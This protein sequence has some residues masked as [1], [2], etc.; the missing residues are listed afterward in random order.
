MGWLKRL[1]GG[2]P[3]D[4]EPLSVESKT[5][6]EA[7]K[8]EHRTTI[9]FFDA[10]DLESALDEAWN[11]AAPP[12]APSPQPD[13]E[14]ASVDEDADVA[15]S[16][17]F[18]VGPERDEERGA[19]CLDAS[20]PRYSREWC[21]GLTDAFKKQLRRIDRK[22]QKRVEEAIAAIVRSPLQPRGKTVQPLTGQ[23]K[24]LWRYR[25]GDYRLIYEPN[26]TQQEITLLAFDDRGSIYQ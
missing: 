14:Q 2:A 24:G 1:F 5:A 9:V 23:Y 6:I 16:A 19:A 4:A 25:V 13:E 18:D 10:I 12:P 11:P 22:L 7:S 21:V 3:A 8:A 26:S 20:P 15:C 17:M